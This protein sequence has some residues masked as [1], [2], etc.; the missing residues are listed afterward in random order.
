M[1]NPLLILEKHLLES[2]TDV[3][4]LLSEE[5][6]M[7]KNPKTGKDILATT[8]RKA[9]S[10]HPAFAAA[11]RLLQGKKMSAGQRRG[12]KKAGIA[13]LAKTRPRKGPAKMSKTI[14]TP[15]QI[16]HKKQRSSDREQVKKGPDT[17]YN[18]YGA[19]N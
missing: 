17:G 18:V 6:D 12:I 16:K 4:E 11:Q 2:I 3:E 1:K 19:D 9:G 14:K 5:G 8:A 13:A 10:S 15:T 7:V